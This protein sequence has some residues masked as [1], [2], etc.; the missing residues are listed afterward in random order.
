M[1]KYLY[2]GTFFKQC[3]KKCGCSNNGQ[4]N[5]CNSEYFQGYDLYNSGRTPQYTLISYNQIAPNTN[6]LTCTSSNVEIQ[7]RLYQNFN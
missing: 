6:G 7:V 2:K 4:C 5:F 1:K 3:F